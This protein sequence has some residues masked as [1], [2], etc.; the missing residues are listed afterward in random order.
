MYHHPGRLPE[1]TGRDSP[2]SA[3]AR[4]AI[5][6]DISR[7]STATAGCTTW[8]VTAIDG[9][10]VCL[11]AVNAAEIRRL[12]DS[13]GITHLNGAPMVLEVAVV[14]V[15]QFPNPGLGPVLQTANRQPVAHTFRYS[16]SISS[17]VG[18]R[19]LFAGEPEANACLAIIGRLLNHS[20][21]AMPYPRGVGTLSR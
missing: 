8:A 16:S 12:L 3:H 4:V 7:C 1:L 17:A 18:T 19:G 14:G 11:R 5:S 10:H 15:P 2:F 20:S 6:V 9:T 21:S 13:E